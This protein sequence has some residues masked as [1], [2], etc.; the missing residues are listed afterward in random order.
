[1]ASSVPACIINIRV[2]LRSFVLPRVDLSHRNI[3]KRTEPCAS[4]KEGQDPVAESEHVGGGD[5]VG[6]T[7]GALKPKTLA[8]NLCEALSWLSTVH[9]DVGGNL[10]VTLFLSSEVEVFSLL[11]AL[12]ESEFRA[13]LED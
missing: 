5:A 8:Q 11:E 1:M 3:T 6:A 7:E 13:F 12:L 2:S 10:S 9:D 4:C